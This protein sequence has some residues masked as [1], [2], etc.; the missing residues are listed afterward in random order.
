[1]TKTLPL[2]VLLGGCA[3]L[4]SSGTAS[5][6]VISRDPG[7][8]ITVDGM[9]AGNAPGMV[10]VANHKDHMI[11]SPRSGCPV[12]SSVGPVW[13]ILDILGGVVPLIVDAATG[14]WKTVDTSAPCML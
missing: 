2:L 10:A 14:A 4:F 7:V 11:A 6:S 3:T 8:P 9:P 5:V 13:V 1:M 12:M